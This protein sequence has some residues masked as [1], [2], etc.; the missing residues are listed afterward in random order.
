MLESSQVPQTHLQFRCHY[1]KGK[2][3][4]PKSKQRFTTCGMCPL[5]N[6]NKGNRFLCRTAGPLPRGQGTII[7]WVLP[8]LPKATRSPT[9]STGKDR[10][11]RERGEVKQEGAAYFQTSCSR[12]AA[13]AAAVRREAGMG[14]S[15]CEK[16][17]SKNSQSGSSTP[18][19]ARTPKPY[20]AK[21]L[22]SDAVAT[23]VTATAAASATRLR[24]SSSSL[25]MP[26][27]PSLTSSSCCSNNLRRTREREGRAACAWPA[28][29]WSLSLW[30]ELRRSRGGGWQAGAW[31]RDLVDQLHLSALS[32][33]NEVIRPTCRGVL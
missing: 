33:V 10:I 15:H 20:V 14:V 4:H 2:N 21:A 1:E 6:F 27:G 23:A 26:P 22:R 25:P 5:S 28:P 32:R 12:S 24:R 11:G 30:R 29:R 16:S 9:Q 13:A 7:S 17:R 8:E 3:L 31:A 19:T 18:A